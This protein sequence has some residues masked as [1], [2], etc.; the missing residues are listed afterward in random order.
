MRALYISATGMK[1]QQ[2]NLDVI[3][4]NLANVNTAGFKKGRADFEDLL[5]QK[6]RPVGASATTNTYVPTGIY[7]GHGS[8]T[9]STSKIFTQGPAK[10]TDL[11]SDISVE[12]QGFFQIDL[13][14]GRVAYTRNGAFKVDANGILTTSNGDPLR[15]QIVIPQ[16]A[17]ADTVAVGLDGTVTYRVQGNAATLEAGQIELASFI[18]P[19]GLEAIGSNLFLESPSSGA[20]LIGTPGDNG[21]GQTMGGWLEQSNV[22]IVDEL[23]D[24]IVGQRA[25][26]IN[27][28][29]IV[30]ADEM[31]ETAVN[32]KR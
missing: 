6:M 17:I 24:M 30:V 29:S 18:N 22:S 5:Y 27:S 1:S 2:V 23:V 32:V 3:S 31:L 11:W 10:F 8:R 12:G 25:Y 26:E 19:A 14:D 7:V 13:P 28:K 21:M 16:D 4:N 20:P 15:P 9:A